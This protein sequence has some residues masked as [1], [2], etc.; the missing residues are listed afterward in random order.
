MPG[1]TRDLKTYEI[2]MLEGHAITETDRPNLNMEAFT[3]ADGIAKAV[4]EAG[5]KLAREL[6]R[7]KE[8]A[9]E[10]ERGGRSR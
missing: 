4:I 10:R 9:Q 7:E 3:L 8:R 2:A 6:S 5:R 1:F